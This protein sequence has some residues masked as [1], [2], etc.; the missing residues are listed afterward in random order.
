MRQRQRSPPQRRQAMDALD[1]AGKVILKAFYPT[2]TIAY[3]DRPKGFKDRYRDLAA[4]ALAA[5]REVEAV[6]RASTTQPK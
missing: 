3:E 4:V 6:A 1:E 5:P 2:L